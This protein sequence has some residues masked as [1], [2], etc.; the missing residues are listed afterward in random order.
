MLLV[1]GTPSLGDELK[2]WLDKAKQ[3][4]TI[5]EPSI[6]ENYSENPIPE[7]SGI[8]EIKQFGEITVAEGDMV[9]VVYSGSP[10]T[11]IVPSTASHTNYLPWDGDVAT[12]LRLDH[13]KWGSWFITSP[14]TGC[15]VWIAGR[16]DFEPLLIHINANKFRNNPLQNLIY[17]QNLAMEVLTYFNEVVMKD[18]N[19]VFM[20]RVSYD[21]ANAPDTPDSQRDKINEYWNAMIFLTSSTCLLLLSTQGTSTEHMKHIS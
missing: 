3:V 1:L 20:Q 16:P 2:N 10:S 18:N 21:Y 12:F 19:Y 7:Y 17:K 8:V 13:N 11:P 4:G 6:L 5:H 15:D 9:L 14:L